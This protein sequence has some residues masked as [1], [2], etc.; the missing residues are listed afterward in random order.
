MIDLLAALALATSPAAEVPPV[1][2][3][4]EATAPRRGPTVDY[5]A[6]TALLRDIV[7]DV[8]LSNRQAP[9]RAILTGTRI[10]TGNDSRYRFEG[11]RVAYHLLSEEYQA[12]ISE[13]R[14]DLE[15][16]PDRVDFTGMS[17]DE[18]LAYWLNLHNV[19]VIE[20][21]MLAYP[22]VRLN[23]LNAPGTDEHLYDAKI[24]TV[25]GERLSLN[26]IRLGIVYPQWNDPR[27][28]YGFHN[29]A[30]G[31]PNIRRSA[32]SGR[33]VWQQLDS[34][35]AEFVNSLRGIE[36]DRDELEISSLYAEARDYFFPDWPNDIRS[37]LRAYA[38]DTA[39][40]EVNDGGPIDADVEEW[41]VADLI[42][43]SRR[44]TGGA[45]DL[46]LQ[47][48][49]GDHVRTSG[50]C[51]NMPANAQILVN[52]VIERRRELIRDGA[53]GRV[54]VRDVPTTDPDESADTASPAVD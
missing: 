35:A 52:H 51:A 31:G 28:M 44:C 2:T 9:Q 30:I 25:A 26:D 20:Q 48:Y 27:V 19:A 38:V 45:G 18:Q 5:S 13:Y 23:R 49:I 54:Y 46:Q 29:G 43:G 16:L 53:Y 39:A 37:H 14:R 42:N 15:T 4:P 41:G 34:N 33:D 10:N 50:S 1:F 11:N 24:L 36:I 32:Y 40:D 22:V 12:A 17:S 7:L 47:T 3:R 8:G 6:W 21:I